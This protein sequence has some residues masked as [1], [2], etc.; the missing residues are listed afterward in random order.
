VIGR[1]LISTAAGIF[2]GVL[3]SV[4]F[5]KITPS[6]IVPD[7]AMI[8]LIATAWRYGSLAGEIT[9]FLIGISFDAMGLAPLG[10]HAFLFTLIGYLF[11]RMQDSVSPGPM[12][13]PVIGTAIATFLKYGGSFFLS[14]I[15]GLNSGALRYFSL[16][17]VWELVANILISPLVFLLVAFSARMFE[18]KRGGFN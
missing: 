9:G 13:L 18:G 14:M 8:I 16:N 17:T 7:I 5:S 11:G 4:F 12:I 15:F 6:G 2:F 1:I 10:F 3:Q